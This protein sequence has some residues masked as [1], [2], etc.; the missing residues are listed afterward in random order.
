LWDDLSHLCDWWNGLTLTGVWV[1]SRIGVEVR[2]LE[3]V[4]LS[5]VASA[6]TPTCV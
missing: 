5:A 6:S 4:R 1:G 3:E 2:R